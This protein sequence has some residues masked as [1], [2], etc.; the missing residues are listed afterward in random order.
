M[1]FSEFVKLKL[2][3]EM[4]IEG[5]VVRKPIRL[6]KD[7]I[8]FLYQFPPELWSMAIRKRYHDDLSEALDSRHKVRL[9][10]KEKIEE[11]AKKA[12]RSRNFKQLE[13]Y[14]KYFAKD[15]IDK[16][17]K[18]YNKNEKRY[19]QD[20]GSEAFEVAIDNAAK[21][22]SYYIIEKLHPHAPEPT[23]TGDKTYNFK[24]GKKTY[25]I[26]AKP[27]INRLIHK[28]EKTEGDSHDPTIGLHNDEHK[29]GQYGYDLQNIFKGHGLLPGESQGMQL[30]TK[31]MAE[32]AIKE[33]F[34]DNYQHY[35]GQ[36][37]SVGEKVNLPNGKQVNIH[38]E[39]HVPQFG[40]MPHRIDPS[41]EE[42][43]KR[44]KLPTFSHKVYFIEK[45]EKGRERKV[46]KTINMPF[47][48]STKYT[49]HVGANPDDPTRIGKR[50]DRIE[51]SPSDFMDV[52]TDAGVSSGGSFTA[53]KNRAEERKK[54]FGVAGAKEEREKAIEN[55]EKYPPDDQNYPN[56]YIPIV[57]GI[58]QGIS[59][60][61]PY[62]N[63][64][65]WE[66]AIAKSNIKEVHDMILAKLE[67]KAGMSKYRT[68]QAV[69][70]Y[71]KRTVI[72][73]LGQDIHGGGTRRLR[74]S[75]MSAPEVIPSSLLTQDQKDLIDN[76]N[77]MHDQ[78]GMTGRKPIAGQFTF[79]YSNLARIVQ[80]LKDESA[81]AEK[82]DHIIGASVEK[83]DKQIK[84]I[85]ETNY[86][87]KA[88]L[89]SAMRDVLEKL[90][91]TSSAGKV[92]G[93]EAHE[94][95]NKVISTILNK[96]TMSIMVASFAQLKIV[97]DYLRQQPI[98]TVIKS[99]KQF[100]DTQKMSMLPAN[101]N[102][103]KERA[104]SAPSW[105]ILSAKKDYLALIFR[106]DFMSKAPKQTI[107]SLKAW[108]DSQKEQNKI[109]DID[110]AEAT[111][112]LNHYLA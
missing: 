95:A 55:M 49:Q 73:I 97:Q 26:R 77:Q 67:S 48:L 21:N 59:Q 109:S 37:P 107:E 101:I 93:P 44:I 102:D 46:E 92:Q 87:R 25:S 11:L 65:D 51:I 64:R 106:S 111:E 94:E 88:L 61:I 10:D 84:E 20:Q 86:R 99:P 62:T 69:K 19:Y 35:Y 17:R 80:I 78:L 100:K 47:V 9:S 89:L 54:K 22:I 8:E 29:V 45:D 60:Q 90:I 63:I 1:K 91:F 16:L 38:G 28:L 30:I 50:K 2:F 33:F 15:T 5:D 36:L 41:I 105:N 74:L 72:S 108:I 12:I 27:Y 83:T 43:D 40:K 3:S 103:P 79:P 4:A 96:K 98:E 52:S 23:S 34:K 75:Q 18:D 24:I 56:L 81:K 104:E 53:N 58:F 112:E 39:M 76:L 70:N 66:A 71:A 68:K 57:N 14:P 7:D 85:F 42:D 6:D 13:N 82:E 31:D 32:E 110:H